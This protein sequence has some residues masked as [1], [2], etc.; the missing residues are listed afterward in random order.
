MRRRVALGLPLSLVLHAAAV[1]AVLTLVSRQDASPALF[2][3]LTL[4]RGPEAPSPPRAR[5]PQ[6]AGEL[7]LARKGRMIERPPDP[8]PAPPAA[9]MLAESSSA[10]AASAA[11]APRPAVEPLIEPAMEQREDPRLR[12]PDAAA[13]TAAVTLLP[14][15]PGA[16]PA[17]AVGRNDGE[18]MGDN[19]SAAGPGPVDGGGIAN[20]TRRAPASSGGGNVSA[21]A[22]VPGAGGDALGAEY[23][24]YLAGL[25]SQVAEALRYPLAARRR[26]LT[27][28][29]QLEILIR[30]NGAIGTAAVVLSSSHTILDEAALETVRGL[31]P[32]SFPAHLAPRILRVR[33]PI[34]FS[35][36]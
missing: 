10:S 11:S 31:R 22:L 4:E 3:D 12:P 2:I 8:P 27:G 29:V 23:G 28:T 30:A 6:P 33:L 34:V 36:A 15:A 35:L 9:R 32:L 5:G 24:P 16:A 26:R 18:K 1:G 20:D 13:L 17:R 7:R 21:V 14:A 25:R 19:P